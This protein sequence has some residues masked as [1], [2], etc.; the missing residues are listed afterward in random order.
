MPARIPPSPETDG[1]VQRGARNRERIVDALMEL[2]G[3]GELIP[4]AEQVA[5]RAEVGT[6]TVFRH[7]DDMDSLFAEMNA[8]L[9]AELLPLA[10][11]PVPPGSVEERARALVAQRA[12][13]F[14]RLAPYKRSGDLQRWRS[15]FLQS[16]HAR[17]VRRMRARLLKVLPELEDAPSAVLEA[18]DQATSFEA[19]NR[20][21]TDQRLGRDR[22]A[23][24]M[25]AAV[26]AL[27]RR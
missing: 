3:E 10:D 15:P 1:R 11:K 5:L 13:L 17:M 26:L 14:E 25:E 27:A 12:T 7:F 16:N 2:I 9:E 23:E 22:A 18:L 19:W 21:R 4:T 20:L 6:R 8:R 24:V